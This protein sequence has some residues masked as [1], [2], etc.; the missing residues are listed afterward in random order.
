M[1]QELIR[2]ENLT[3]N[4]RLGESIVHALRGVSLK[5]DA[6]EF[7]SIMGPSGSG[8]TTL[9]NLLGALD[10]P[11]SGKV[12]LDGVDL[13]QVSE[14]KLY[15]VRRNKVGFVFQHFYLI[16]TLTTF[17]NVL[18]PVIPV[19][20]NR[21]FRDR[22][23]KL[24]SMVG[25]EERMNHKPNQLSGGEQQRVAICRA[26]INSPEVLFCDE[27]TGELDSATGEK[28]IHLL[29]EINQTEGVTVVFVTHDPIVSSRSNRIITLKDGKI[30]SDRSPS[31]T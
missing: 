3:K 27:I 1:A 22:A 25:L 5:I 9:L 17:E 20:N 23:E 8:K 30:T 13:T 16:P 7:L 26:L 31:S 4:Y 10:L 19:E 6:G 24:L 18:V 29:K 11:T 15:E 28:I 14:R 2:T 21:R 12:F